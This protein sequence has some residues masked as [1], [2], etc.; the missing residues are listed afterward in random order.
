MARPRKQP[1][2]NQQLMTETSS[3]ETVQSSTLESPILEKPWVVQSVKEK[4]LA[5]VAIDNSLHIIPFRSINKISTQY[6]GNP[7]SSV[8][9]I[10]VNYRIEDILEV[11]EW[12]TKVVS[13][14]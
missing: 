2:N 7:T 4:A 9:G 14:S 8:N 10:L 12:D 11:L 1:L 13:P 6:K 3:A 5:V